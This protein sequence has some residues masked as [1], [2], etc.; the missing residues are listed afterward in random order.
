MTFCGELI[1]EKAT[2]PYKCQTGLCC[3]VRK[4]SCLSTAIIHRDR[5]NHM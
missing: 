4:S 1:L 5:H 2:C 3:H